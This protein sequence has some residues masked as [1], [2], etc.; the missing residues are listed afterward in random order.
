MLTEPGNKRDRVQLKC[1]TCEKEALYTLL[2]RNN[3]ARAC[4]TCVAMYRKI[5]GMRIEPI[6]QENKDENTG[7]RWTF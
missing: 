6:N 4:A 5:S 2:Y 3:I 1:S 7:R